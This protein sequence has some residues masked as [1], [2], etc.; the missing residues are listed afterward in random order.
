MKP[1]TKIAVTLTLGIGILVSSLGVA[2][3][4]PHYTD[5]NGRV[6]EKPIQ[7]ERDTLK[8]L[9]VTPLQRNLEPNVWTYRHATSFGDGPGFRGC[10]PTDPD[11]KDWLN[12]CIQAPV[13]PSAFV[14]LGDIQAP[15]EPSAFVKLGDIQAPVEPSA[16]V[17]LGDIQAPVEPSAYV[18]LG[19]I[20]APVEPLAYV[21]LGD[22]QAP[23]EVVISPRL[24]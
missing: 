2:S 5:F 8:D 19:D 23:V 7:V 10:L 6:V 16:Y 1:R 14:K 24:F 18:K 4:S 20:Q 17:K 15:V 3:A 13:E 9:I 11:H 22:I 21:K 12:G